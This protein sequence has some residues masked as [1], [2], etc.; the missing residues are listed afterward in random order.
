MYE[1]QSHYGDVSSV[2]S[3]VTVSPNELAALLQSNRST[4]DYHYYW[5]S[6]IA[7]VAPQSIMSKE[8][9]WYNRLQSKLPLEALDPRGPSLWIGT[10]GS[11]TQCH[12]DVA[13]NIVVQLFGTKRIRIYTPSV[14][15]YNLH[16]YPD[17]HP[18]ARKSQVDFDYADFSN[19]SGSIHSTNIDDASGVSDDSFS[20]SDENAGKI[21]Q[22]FP[23]FSAVP[24]PAMDVT[25]QPGDALRI[26][27]FWFHHV[28]NGH[29]PTNCNWDHATT[30]N[31]EV[32]EICGYNG[33]DDHQPS[34][35]FNSFALSESMMIA[36]RIFQSASRPLGGK[37]GVSY[38]NAVPEYG[39]MENSS[40]ILR[41]LGI[42]LISGLNV[43]N[44]GEEKEFIRT[45]LLDARY[46]PLLHLGNN[47]TN[48]SS[49]EK[50]RNGKKSPPPPLATEQQRIISLCV[51]KILPSFHQ[52]DGGGGIE[53][54]AL[55][56]NRVYDGCANDENGIKLLVALHLLEL[57]AVELVGPKLVSDA[58]ERA[59]S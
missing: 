20:R 41:A 26:P 39:S 54:D 53:E 23:H 34:V 2:S 10:S 35:S 28:E 52:L 38:P 46:S 47:S 33:I 36:R 11:G 19:S 18:K 8:F 1:E 40:S 44:C 27:A 58:W 31:D 45:Y 59:L 48:Y 4:S 37:R 51:E 9:H 7:D 55:N 16:V 12:Y 42:A 25:L 6:P 3:T 56:K 29:V 13:D 21:F 14:G 30:S 15:V 49:L 32:R 24:N 50:D 5:T 17:A 43:V 57:W 22:R